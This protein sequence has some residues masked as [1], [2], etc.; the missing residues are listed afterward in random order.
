MCCLVHVHIPQVSI[1][2]VWHIINT[3]QIVIKCIHCLT[4]K[5]RQKSKFPQTSEP[6]HS[7]NSFLVDLR[8]N[9]LISVMKIVEN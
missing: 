7:V 3:Q 1:Y 9:V 4:L 2:I 5:D 8:V 6:I